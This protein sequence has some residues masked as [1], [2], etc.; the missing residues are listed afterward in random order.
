M[1]RQNDRNTDQNRAYNV[2]YNNNKIFFQLF[3]L[4][5]LKRIKNTE[6]YINTNAKSNFNIIGFI[7][8]Y[9]Y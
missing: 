6:N 5:Y 7:L 4:F 1:K 8:Q 2:E 9:I 3:D